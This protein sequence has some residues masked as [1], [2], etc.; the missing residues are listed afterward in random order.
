MAGPRD[1]RAL[2]FKVQH[3]DSSGRFLG[4]TA[5][6]RLYAIE[7][8]IRVL[9]HSVLS[10]QINPKWWTVAVDPKIQASAKGL[11]SRYRPPWHTKANSHDIY[12]TYLRDLAEIIRANSN[13]FRKPIPD[14]D[15]WLVRIELIP[16]PRNITCHMNF[17]HT[18]DREWLD[19]LYADLVTLLTKLQKDGLVLGNP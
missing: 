2:A 9:I 6:F 5:Y 19:T 4:R 11:R 16:V 15:Q 3:V 18:L 14:I 12:N 1:F 7:N 13:L 8:L 10:A 17:L